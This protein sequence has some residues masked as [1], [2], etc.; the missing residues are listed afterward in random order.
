MLGPEP[1]RWPQSPPL[2]LYPKPLNYP[3]LTLG[4]KE[5]RHPLALHSSQQGTQ[6]KTS[7]SGSRSKP[8]NSLAKVRV[9]ATLSPAGVNQRSL[10]TEVHGN[11]IKQSI[12]PLDP[13]Q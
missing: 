4:R 8:H 3:G 1:T 11:T 13:I 2:A 5:E 12:W 6:V 7:A 10:A 9:T